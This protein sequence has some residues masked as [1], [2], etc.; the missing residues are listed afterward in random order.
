MLAPLGSTKHC[1]GLHSVYSSCGGGSHSEEPTWLSP[2]GLLLLLLQATRWVQLSAFCRLLCNLLQ[3]HSGGS[4]Q[5]AADACMPVVPL[6]CCC[7]NQST[8]RA[9]ILRSDA[10][11]LS[12]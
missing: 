5:S 3:E 11:I 2:Q 9:S 10:G 8:L 12:L 7:S 6:H 4:S 1:Q